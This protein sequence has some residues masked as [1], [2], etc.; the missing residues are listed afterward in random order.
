M[1]KRQFPAALNELRNFLLW[2]RKGS[3]FQLGHFDGT[4]WIW[5]RSYLDRPMLTLDELRPPLEALD[6]DGNPMFHAA[7]CPEGTDIAVIDFDFKKFDE[8]AAKYPDKPDQIAKTR[9]MMD[10]WQAQLSE[11]TFVEQSKTQGCYH[12][13]VSYPHAR[14]SIGADADGNEIKLPLDLLGSGFVVLTGD[15]Q[16][17]FDAAAPQPDDLSMIES[18]W[19]KASGD[20]A[21][22][23]QVWFGKGENRRLIELNAP[24][25]Y[26][27][28][29]ADIDVVRERVANFGAAY[30]WYLNGDGDCPVKSG[31]HNHVPRMAFLQA[32]AKVCYGMPNANE[33][34][35]EVISTSHFAIHYTPATS[36][37]NKR[38]FE[39]PSQVKWIKN[40]EI[41]LALGLAHE[42][43]LADKAIIDDFRPKAELLL[44]TSEAKREQERAQAVVA[45]L[46]PAAQL[47]VEINMPDNFW[48]Q[49]VQKTFRKYI[50]TETP[51]WERT[52]A[53]F[54]TG[55][56]ASSFMKG[57]GSAITPA[58]VT[59]GGTG[60]GKATQHDFLDRI[61]RELSRPPFF[62]FVGSLASGQAIRD[63]IS[64]DWHLIVRI[65][66][67][68]A[69]FEELGS[70]QQK[71]SSVQEFLPNALLGKPLLRGIRANSSKEHAN[72]YVERPLLSMLLGIQPDL[73]R[74]AFDF[75][76]ITGGVFGRMVFL[77]APPKRRL[78][79]DV[80]VLP[81]NTA[82]PD[83]AFIRAIFYAV[84]GSAFFDRV[85]IPTEDYNTS[86][87]KARLDQAVGY[88]G[89]AEEVFHRMR[90]QSLSYA[91]HNLFARSITREHYDA[92][93][94]AYKA[95]PSIEH[96]YFGFKESVQCQLK[97]PEEL[98][99]ADLEYGLSVMAAYGKTL[100]YFLE[101]ETGPQI[102]E[103]V[104]IKTKAKG[105]RKAIEEAQVQA[106]DTISPSIA[107]R[108]AGA[109]VG[110]GNKGT[111]KVDTEEMLAW[112]E[113]IRSRAGLRCIKT[114]TWQFT[115]VTVE[116][117]NGLLNDVQRPTP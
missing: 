66:E 52:T 23:G 26:E 69:F 84:A 2:R 74:N 3:S 21:P 44:L 6:D 76:Q 9:E 27:H 33:L 54:C 12:A 17:D 35:W 24:P 16:N 87:Y 34:I 49:H 63:G 70:N 75:E 45:K 57:S 82:D 22:M 8:L 42:A 18:Y 20:P 88:L 115:D 108:K 90:Q 97:L 102:D 32:I 110:K 53:M 78:D 65:E 58:I 73:L 11:Y 7:F 60:V 25:I 92:F 71:R 77:P 51:F 68:K 96:R 89:A 37:S 94:A 61:F 28:E 40:K 39:N 83:V 62:D 95:N 116:F 47:S 98:E 5:N 79:P 107:A 46:Q 85:N 117:L 81:V 38:R 50:S 80:Y 103:F 111:S 36:N 64:N 48:F 112:F 86:E 105:L 67:A 114:G 101:D 29:D 4:N 72:A 109:G 30:A 19:D 14:R 43:A 59:I 31:V 55:I 91:L 13:L 93:I 104:R 41:P 106:V 113:Q 10:A 100:V 15:A 99:P 56:L 1:F